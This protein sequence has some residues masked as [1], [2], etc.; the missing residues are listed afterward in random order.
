FSSH[1]AWGTRSFVESK[2][3]AIVEVDISSSSIYEYYGIPFY[4]TD[5]LLS[6]DLH[7]FSNVDLDAILNY[8]TEGRREWKCEA[9]TGVSIEPG[10]ECPQWP[11]DSSDSSMDVTEEEEDDEEEEREKGE[12][13]DVED[14]EDGATK[15]EMTYQD[16]FA[17]VFTPVRPLTKEDL[18]QLE[19]PSSSTLGQLM[20]S[21]LK[22]T[23]ADQNAPILY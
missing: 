10:V 9:L 11:E 17:K 21:S 1:V 8:L 16:D 4:N 23:C 6:I 15:D 18:E 13:M 7:F 12:G 20:F 5:A 14:D 22:F 2:N 3:L 19:W